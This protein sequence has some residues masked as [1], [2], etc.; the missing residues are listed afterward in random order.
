MQC[1]CLVLL[2]SWPYLALIVLAMAM[3]GSAAPDTGTAA[4]PAGPQPIPG[5][6]FEGPDPD[7]VVRKVVQRF[8]L[9]VCAQGLIV[10]L[11]QC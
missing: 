4:A 5:T 2:N 11:S 3:G 10:L 7:D 9:N 6:Q 8:S 1:P